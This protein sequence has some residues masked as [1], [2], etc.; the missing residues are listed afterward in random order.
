[1]HTAQALWKRC[2]DA[3]DIYLDS[4]SGRYN[5]REETFVTDSD[6]QLADY[7]DPVSGKPLKKVEEA[8]NIF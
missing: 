6:A 7:K 1:M 5:V 4:Y 2:A 3:G 8:S